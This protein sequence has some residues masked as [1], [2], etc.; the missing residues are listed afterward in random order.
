M[1][2][3][4]LVIFYLRGRP[5]FTQAV[6]WA[7][8]KMKWPRQPKMATFGTQAGHRLQGGPQG[9]HGQGRGQVHGQGQG[10]NEDQSFEK[11]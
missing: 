11:N 7:Q 5:Y 8:A 1:E 9:L 6:A 10:Q 4:V 3:T 2:E